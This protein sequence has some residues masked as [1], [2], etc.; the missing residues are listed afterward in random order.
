[1]IKD[2]VDMRIEMTLAL[3]GVDLLVAVEL[4][5]WWKQLFG[6]EI[7][8]LEITELGSLRKMAKVAAER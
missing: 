4:C 3:L 7:S 2:A 8:V 1:M 6:L 5:R